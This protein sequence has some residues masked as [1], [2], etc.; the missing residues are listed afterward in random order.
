M[1]SQKDRVKYVTKI[2]LELDGEKRSIEVICIKR[3]VRY[4]KKCGT[5]TTAPDPTIP[6]T[7]YGKNLASLIGG[8][9]PTSRTL[10]DITEDIE[11]LFGEV[12]SQN[13]VKN[14]VLALA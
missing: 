14:C 5:W 11:N 6:G 1:P 7:C 2:C 3:E 10:L 8:W 9:F 13:S 12:V 4:C